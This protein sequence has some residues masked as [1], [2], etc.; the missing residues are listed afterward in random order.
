MA[1]AGQ[2]A[3][4]AAELRSALVAVEQLKDTTDIAS[5]TEGIRRLAGLAGSFGAP[6]LYRISAD[7]L[8]SPVGDARALAQLEDAIAR[9]GGKDLQIS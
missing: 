6:D 5:W 2:D 4:L 8:A 3:A 1:A 9:L 7:A